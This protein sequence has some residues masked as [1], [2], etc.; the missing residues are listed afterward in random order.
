MLAAAGAIS[1]VMRVRMGKLMEES[2]PPGVTIR[3]WWSIRNEG[4]NLARARFCRSM[5]EKCRK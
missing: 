1:A 4:G 5:A 3:H 2:K